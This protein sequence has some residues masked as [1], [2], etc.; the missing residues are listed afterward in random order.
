[1]KE[2]IYYVIKDGHCLCSFNILS[3]AQNYAKQ[4]KGIIVNQSG[5]K[6]A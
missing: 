3:D 1:M 4:V 5:D 2:E 6:I